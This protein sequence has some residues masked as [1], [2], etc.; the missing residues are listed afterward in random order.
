MPRPRLQPL[1]IFAAILA[2]AVAIHWPALRYARPFCCDNI[3]ILE[4][5]DAASMPDA[6]IGNERFPLE[7]RPLPHLLVLAEYRLWGVTPLWP[8]L[9]LNLFVWSACVALVFALARRLTGSALGAAVATA[10]L[11]TAGQTSA[12]SEFLMETQ[13]AFACLFGLAAVSLALREGPSSRRTTATIAALLFAACLGKEYGLAFA[14][15]LAVWAGLQQR[16]SL[17]L[18]SAAALALYLVLRA[19]LTVSGLG[20]EEHA[21]FGSYRIVCLDRF[22]AAALTQATYNAGASLLQTLIP[23]LLGD[24]GLVGIAPLRLVQAAFWLVFM[25][26][27]VRRAPWVTLAVLVI[28]ANA[29]LQA[30]L[31][32]SRN[33]IVGLTM[34]ALLVGSGFTVLLA[35]LRSLPWATPARLLP[36]VVLAA[37]A[38]RAVITSG[39]VSLNARHTGI[40]DP[41]VTV[42]QPF[43][44]DAGFVRRLKTAYGL[45]D[46][47]C[48]LPATER[49]LDERAADDGPSG[50]M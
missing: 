30:P 12:I 15:G 34:V 23:G 50:R 18:G 22:D 4:W 11:L 44:V 10:F 26:L 13:T 5:A 42:H 37:L 48:A 39:N 25:A 47:D 16:R 7:W 49:L 41:C 43:P 28:L 21:F 36:A 3:A 45:P 32:R 46:P 19:T 29:A 35:R 1:L 27:G 9:L 14:A 2:V 33:T 31:Y 38:V 40:Q 8:Y 6:L 17:A 24:D 20:C